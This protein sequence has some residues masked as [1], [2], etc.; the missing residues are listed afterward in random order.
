MT[1]VPYTGDSTTTWGQLGVRGREGDGG[2]TGKEGQA[3]IQARISAS[4]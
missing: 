2:G 3:R 4:F 1:S